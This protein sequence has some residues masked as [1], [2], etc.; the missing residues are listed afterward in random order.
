MPPFQ[1]YYAF[2]SI[3][4]FTRR[5][6]SGR[7]YSG[8]KRHNPFRALDNSGLRGASADLSARRSPTKGQKI[9]YLGRSCSCVYSP[10]TSVVLRPLY[11]VQQY[12]LFCSWF[13]T[14][15]LLCSICDT[16]AHDHEI[17]RV[18]GRA[19]NNAC[20]V[21]PT[22]PPRIALFHIFKAGTCTTAQAAH[23]RPTL[24]RISPFFVSYINPQG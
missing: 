12:H 21:Y 20:C 6:Y 9:I 5:M 17:L 11:L 8:R 14:K 22:C 24:V 2:S 1:N 7:K 13:A 16:D 3:T 23:V 4:S 18:F 15:H 19:N 10:P